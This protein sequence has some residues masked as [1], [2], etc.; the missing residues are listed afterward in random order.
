MA[1]A[2]ITVRISETYNIHTPKWDLT[3]E[4]D[5]LVNEMYF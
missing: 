4:W 2:N 5:C 1:I 3:K